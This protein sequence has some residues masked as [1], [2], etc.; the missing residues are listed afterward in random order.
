MGS[1]SVELVA[2]GDVMID[3]HF[4]LRD[5]PS[6]DVFEWV[7]RG[8]LVFA[9]L[10]CPLGT[11]GHPREKM[12][13]FRSSPSIARLLRAMGLH[14]VSLANN[15]ML[16]YGE[17][18]L[19][20][21]LRILTRSRIKY[22]GAGKNITDAYKPC[23][24]TKGGVR[25]AFL[26]LA[27]TLPLGSAASERRPGVAPVHV[28]TSYQIDPTMLQEQ[29]GDHPRI[30]TNVETKDEKRILKVISETRKHADHVVVGIHWG[31]AFDKQRAEYQQ[32]LGRKMIE[33]GA[34]LIV[35]HHPHLRQGIEHHQNGVILYSLGDFVFHDRV[36]MTGES[37][38][39]ANIEF[40]RKKI[41]TLRLKL[42]Q[43]DAKSGLPTFGNKTELQSLVKEM[44][45]SS[46]RQKLTLDDDTLKVNV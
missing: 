41:R 27:A 43:I 32:P 5:W 10:E 8:D 6:S 28:R 40:D 16:D 35:G 2:L 44:R 37:G 12:F 33:A 15:H 25:I 45:Q 26:G 11:K 46:S 13:A 9:N 19:D 3:H 22:V 4:S 31:V 29:P 23:I 21:T 30:R 39:I 7:S 36:D 24:I 42:I 34:S 20:E 18:A 38:M 17:G 14:V 1:M